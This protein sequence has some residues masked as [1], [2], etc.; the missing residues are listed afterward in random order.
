MGIPSGFKYFKNMAIYIHKGLRNSYPK[1][2][3]KDLEG[4]FDTADK[5]LYKQRIFCLDCSDFET[6]RGRFWQGCPKRAE[7]LK[8]IR[9]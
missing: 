8:I 2:Y 9:R 1:D 5:T 7:A 4:R 6:C 3:G